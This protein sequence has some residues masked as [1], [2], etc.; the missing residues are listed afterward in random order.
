MKQLRLPKRISLIE[1]FSV[2]LLFGIQVNAQ[3]L[4]QSFDLSP[5]WNAIYLHVDPSHATIDELIAEDSSNPIQE[6]WL[7]TPD[8]STLQF[9]TSPDNPSDTNTRWLSWH[10]DLGSSSSR[11]AKM[12]GNAAFLVRLDDKSAAYTWK[13][14][15]KPV[16]PNYEWTTT[17]EN[18]I[19]FPIVENQATNFGGFLKPAPHLA[20][21]DVFAYSGGS[22]QNNPKKL[23]NL[24]ATPIVRGQGFW[25][26]ADQTY[27]RYFG[28]LSVE[29]S[30]PA[31]I[32]F[33][34]RPGPNR[35]VLINTTQ[36]AIDVSIAQSAS[37]S[38]PGSSDSI[39]M[40]DVLV[41]SDYDRD[42]Q[43]YTYESLAAG[44]LNVSLK[45]AERRE[46]VLGPD[47]SSL[48]GGVGDLSAGVLHFSDG[49]GLTRIDVPVSM[50]KP[51]LSGLWIGEAKITEVRHELGAAGNASFGGVAEPY[52]VRLIVHVGPETVRVD[53]AS[54]PG[55]V[56]E[57]PNSDPD[58]VKL[59]QR[60][61]YGLRGE[62]KTVL[63]TQESFLDTA[64]LGLARRISS[65]HFPFSQTNQWWRCSGQVQGGST[66]NVSVDLPFDDQ[67]SN[68][69]LHRYHPDHDNLTAHFNEQQASG[70]ESYGVK[71]DIEIRFANVNSE[72]FDKIVVANASA[73]GIYS[74]TITLQGMKTADGQAFETKEYA[75]Q[76]FVSFIRVSELPDL[77]TEN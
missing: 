27:N 69:F 50:Q 30:D 25:I 74:E 15:G 56:R 33:S 58:R 63:A 48:A 6:I 19:G 37:E 77:V 32:D 7:W 14:K 31:G 36:Q 1:L 20:R 72:D 71:R 12:V 22:L 11:L 10:R 57:V 2:V 60:I 17:G 29:L 54:A 18:F 34:S 39:P 67:R 16:P 8:L 9:V 42:R 21:A 4:T 68:P 23:S 5:G 75:V 46:L 13:I 65:A 43:L 73:S 53:D 52:S 45:P 38:A 24:A 55:G 3:W 44:P 41:R 47:A 76:G 62:T 64:T 35:V 51:G 70:I 28:P 49:L 61:Y 59:L 26:R 66:L 40:V